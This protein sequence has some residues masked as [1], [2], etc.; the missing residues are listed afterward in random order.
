VRCTLST[1]NYDYIILRFS[2]A[3]SDKV[4]TRG[5]TRAVAE[6]RVG[7]DGK[8]TLRVSQPSGGERGYALSESVVYRPYFCFPARGVVLE[9]KPVVLA[10]PVEKDGGLVFNVPAYV[11]LPQARQ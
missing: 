4:K 8:L 6:W 3:V 10:E 9:V 2:P 7:A 1:K 11:T 5:W